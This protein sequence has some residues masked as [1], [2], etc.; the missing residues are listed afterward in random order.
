LCMVEVAH[1]CW[2]WYVRQYWY[3]SIHLRIVCC[4]SRD[5]V[6]L[7]TVA[8]SWRGWGMI[9][10]RRRGMVGQLQPCTTGRYLHGCWLSR[11]N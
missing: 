5:I 7:G 4:R 10:L 8:S 6:G 9:A 3:I 1:L 2:C 11:Y